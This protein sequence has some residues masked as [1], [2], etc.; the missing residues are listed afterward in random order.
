MTNGELYVIIVLFYIIKDSRTFFPTAYDRE[1]NAF[2]MKKFSESQ[3]LAIVIAIAAVTIIAVI[4]AAVLYIKTNINRSVKIAELNGAVSI[5]RNGI[6]VNP[7]AGIPLKS[8]DVITTT[9]ESTIRVCIDGDKWVSFEPNSSAYINYDGTVGNGSTYVNVTNGAVIA[10]LDKSLPIKSVFAVK[11]PNAVVNAR[12]TVFRTEFSLEN[13]FQNYKDVYV[14]TVHNIEGTVALQLYDQNSQPVENNMLLLTKTSAQMISCKDITEYL[15]LNQ[16]YSAADLKYHTLKELIRICSE[17]NI[18]FTLSELNDALF[19]AAER[20]L[21]DSTPVQTTITEAEPSEVTTTVTEEETQTEA[22]TEETTTTTVP[23][24]KTAS[25]PTT[26]ETSESESETSAP[27]T[28]PPETTASEE[29]PQTSAS[30]PETLPVPA[31][32]PP[33]PA[34]TEMSAITYFGDVSGLV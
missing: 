30:E 27:E 2:T 13:D 19:R 31:P 11:T 29:P 12:G 22:T 16:D 24:T 1:V 6:P 15:Y 3:K 26:E 25:E 17:R 7:A 32:V 18:S 33:L 5:T 10:R 4:T 21:V 14:T 9:S 20:L 28:S 23:E 34:D 8:G